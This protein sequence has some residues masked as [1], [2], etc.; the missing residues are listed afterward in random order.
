[1]ILFAADIHARLEAANRST[2]STQG[3]ETKDNRIRRS[4]TLFMLSCLF[5][6]IELAKGNPGQNEFLEGSNTR[7]GVMDFMAMLARSIFE[8]QI[9]E[10]P[11]Y[12]K[13]E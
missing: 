6:S 4:F 9:E 2:I 3:P 10:V 11:N 13:R 12:L 1:M 8:D 5:E 7:Y